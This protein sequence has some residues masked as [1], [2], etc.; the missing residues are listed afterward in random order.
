MD[1]YK[2]WPPETAPR[3]ND[4]SWNVAQAH[5]YRGL[6]LYQAKRLPSG[7]RRIH[8]GDERQAGARGKTDVS[9]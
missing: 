9:A 8:V 6:L 7:G 1:G 3:E 5:Y 2:T 4:S